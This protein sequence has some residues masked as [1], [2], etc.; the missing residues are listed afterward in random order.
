MLAEQGISLAF[1]Q[2]L[3][4]ITG[5]GIVQSLGLILGLRAYG[6]GKMKIKKWRTSASGKLQDVTIE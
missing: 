4:E 6:R 5:E 2:K 1:D 3:S